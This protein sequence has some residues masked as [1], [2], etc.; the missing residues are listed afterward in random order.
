MI[1]PVS[2]VLLALQLFV[3]G[4]SAADTSL[5]SLLGKEIS[6]QQDQDPG[7][8]VDILSDANGS[9]RAA[10]IEFG[11]FLGIG[12]RKVAVPWTALRFEDKS[13]R[14]AILVD[15]TREEIMRLPEYRPTT[16]P[17]TVAR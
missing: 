17:T 3:A 8:I 16:M 4:Q 10:V 11:G 5:Q 2:A 15:L 12:V 7:R 14:T 9:V 1:K 13:G 6:T